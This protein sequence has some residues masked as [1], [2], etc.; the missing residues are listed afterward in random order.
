M[1]TIHGLQ[2]ILQKMPGKTALQICIFSTFNSYFTGFYRARIVIFGG[3]AHPIVSWHKFVQPWLNLGISVHIVRLP[4]RFERLQELGCKDCA[5][6]VKCVCT[7]LKDLNWLTTLPLCFLGY[8]FGAAMAYACAQYAEYEMDAVVQHLICLA[9][10]DRN[11]YNS[12]KFIDLDVGALASGMPFELQDFIQ[13]HEHNM[14]RMNPLFDLNLAYIPQLLA[15][16]FSVFCVGM[17][18]FTLSVV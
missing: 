12:W 7:A 11:I 13:Y 15:L 10:P 9:G 14:G 18:N 6:L 2:T 1:K 5:E 17:F 16:I 4:G 3:M 8:S